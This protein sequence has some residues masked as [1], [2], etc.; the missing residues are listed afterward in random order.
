MAAIEAQ[1]ASVF[2]NAAWAYQAGDYAAVVELLSRPQAADA[3]SLAL[4]A[5]AHL[6]LGDKEA[7]A[8]TFVILADA[9]TD[10]RG[11]F[12]KSA[13]ALYREA[14]SQGK[15]AAIAATAILANPGDRKLA[16]DILRTGGSL[17]TIEDVE[18]LL[19]HL[20]PLN[21]EHVYFTAGFFRHRKKDVERGYATLVAGVDA[22][23]NDVFLKIQRFAA[24]GPVLDF[25]SLRTFD[26]LMREPRSPVAEHV[27]AEQ[28]A[29]QRL[30]WCDDERAN[31]G[32]TLNFRLLCARKRAEGRGPRQRRAVS[33]APAPLRIGYLSNDFGNEVVM[34]VFRPVLE[35]HDRTAFDITLF[36]YSDPDVRKFQETWPESLRSMIVP[37]ADL[38]D[39]QAA[40]AISAAKID[41]LVDLK[42]Y[43]KADRLNI[44][45]LTDAPVT[46]TY[47]G[48]PCSA[49]GADI[50]YLIADPIVT[51]DTSKPHYAEKLCRLPEVQM[52][53]A[54][55]AP[56]GGRSMRR[57]DWGLPDNRF[58]FGSF[59]A[60][61]K[62]TPRVFD[63]WVRILDA[64]PGSVF[65]IALSDGFARKNLLA[66]FARFGID[67]E[68]IIFTGKV[69]RFSD[70]IGRLS[71]ADLALDTLPYNG[72]STTADMLRGGL[73]VLTVKGKS[74]HSRVSW[75]LLEA[76]GIGELAADS[77]DGYCRIAID[78]AENPARLAE[79][80]AR[81][82][83]KRPTS[84]LF[85]PERMA[86]HLERAYRMM[87][88]RVRK[89]LPPDH[90][91]VPALP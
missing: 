81:L 54:A 83:L 59:N 67:A 63:L 90:I 89:G 20:D 25:P 35:R 78:L 73:P 65:W 52:P 61:Y 16:F 8:D 58:V 68:R 10:R 13:A 3:R 40:E 51:P 82:A 30:Y 43:T 14:G 34:S 60:Q 49:Y 9:I 74:Y 87:A 39:R 17:L 4:L 53:N 38:G 1:P 85:D 31:A 91:D 26:A 50:D 11:F 57:S 64:V 48:Y 80:K 79:I 2:E 27:F 62:I 21:P 6:K 84:P 24:A 76:C 47:L 28:M 69:L 75:S 29:L 15:L 19:G 12:L 32:P 22:C 70:H 88:D 42:G 46:A 33:P 71:L 36:C 86:R 56:G 5:N 72:H 44:M 23:P 45:T 66:E 37:I 77:D 55:L 7:G 41:I 18:P